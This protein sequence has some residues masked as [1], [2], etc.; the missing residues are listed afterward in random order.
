MKYEH[1]EVTASKNNR[2]K[3]IGNLVIISFLVILA[4]SFIF[5]WVKEKGRVDSSV[6]ST[7]TTSTATVRFKDGAKATITFKT[8]SSLLPEVEDKFKKI[9]SNYTVP[10]FLILKRSEFQKEVAEEFYSY[11]DKVEL[12]DIQYEKRV[13]MLIEKM[14][15]QKKEIAKKKQD[16]VEIEKETKK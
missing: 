9:F 12:K 14:A 8:E 5:T 11:G 6:V 7:H 1:P 10:E 16:L 15:E 13:R 3:Y 4:L 2:E